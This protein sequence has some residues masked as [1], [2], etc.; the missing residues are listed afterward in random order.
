MATAT[1]AY[2]LVFALLI[3]AGTSA[4]PAGNVL[5]SLNS[6]A[7][8]AANL[9]IQNLSVPLNITQRA[10]IPISLKIVNTGGLA[11]SNIILHLSSFGP[12]GFNQTFYLAALSPGQI[13][14]ISMYLNRRATKAGS[15]ILHINAS[16]GV[17]G[18]VHTSNSVFATYSVFNFSS[19]SLTNSISLLPD[20][21][22]TY[23]PYYNYLLPGQNFVSQ[24][25]VEDTGNVPVYLSANVPLSFS[26][27]L[28][29]STYSLYLAPGEE[30]SSTL[31][32]RPNSSSDIYTIP[33]N[34]TELEADGHK[35]SMVQSMR[36]LVVNESQQ[37]TTILEK[38]SL[39]NDSE[40][41][42]TTIQ[43]QSPQYLGLS[44]GALEVTLPGDVANSLLDV[45]TYGQQSFTSQQNDN[46]L[47]IWPVKSLPQNELEFFYYYV[48]NLN[49]I[50]ALRETQVLFS[51]LS[52]VPEE[53][54]FK[55]ANLG[56]PVLYKNSTGKVTFALSYTGSVPI[57]ATLEFSPSGGISVNN[58]TR[59]VAL[60]PNEFL[61]TSVNV[62]TYN[63]SGTQ[64]LGLSIIAQG[65]NLTYSIPISVLTRAPPATE[66]IVQE[67]YTYK[68][69]III[70][71]LITGVVLFTSKRRPNRQEYNP[72]K[73]KRLITLREQIKRGETAH[74]E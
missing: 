23:I 42:S 36:F 53:N 49:N 72:D 3:A 18:T 67:L 57:E 5:S 13:N 33:I 14:Y 1:G 6:T 19:Q 64:L 35:V 60:R 62:T 73:A 31:L 55:I 47:I 30:L 54:L 52:N 46:Y 11:T 69:I 20:V 41:A 2:S 61:E 44:N 8:M 63:V 34:I 17:N 7:G 15:Y 59:T 65:A 51:S 40:Q 56:V 45:N 38:I 48:N 74:S 22:I 58:A 50:T 10:P 27:V 37:A 28:T 71:V 26:K 43:L 29:L 16:Y 70:I 4:Q 9:S 12:A 68:Y 21:E 24:V 25:S 39:R 32:F 66:I